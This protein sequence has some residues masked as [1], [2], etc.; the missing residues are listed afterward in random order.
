MPFT[1]GQATY[2]DFDPESPL[3]KRGLYVRVVLP[4][5]SGA[6]LYALIDNEIPYCIF[7]FRE[8]GISMPYANNHSVRIHYQV[9]GEGPPLVLQHGF[10]SSLQNWYAYGYV[11][12]LRQNYQLILID[13]RGHGQS[14]KLYD[15]QAYALQH[16]VEDVLAVLDALQVDNAHYLGYSMGGRIGFGIAKYHPERFLSLLIG[17]MHPYE[18]PG[19]SA[20]ARIALLQQGMEAYVADTETHNGP[21]A[22]DRKARLLANDPAALIASLQAPRGLTGMD[23]VLLDMTL[24]CL[25]Y[26]GE[27]DSYYSGAKEG[28]K[29]M[30]NARFVS[31][32]GLNHAQTSQAS[33]L[34]VPHVTQFLHEVMQDESG[35]RVNQPQNLYRM[36][37]PSPHPQP[38]TNGR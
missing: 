17:G 1:T 38:G 28:L 29:Y 15:P 2:R 24:P 12:A 33:H 5:S 37:E 18:S 10:T 31:F 23:Q 4:D 36:Q 20:E 21:M 35:P 13:A 7:N 3:R 14:D 6:S 22:P 16:R 19:A 8:E 30:S 25:L 34:V 9:E 32:P 27:A 11:A 26:V